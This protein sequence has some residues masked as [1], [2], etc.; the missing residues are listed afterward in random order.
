MRSLAVLATLTALL[1]AGCGG[2]DGEREL[3]PVTTT[4]APPQTG[5]SE[6]QPRE[7]EADERERPDAGRRYSR[8]PASL[9]DCIRAGAGVEDVIVKG[10][11]SEDATFFADLVGGRVDVLGVTVRGEPAE[12]GV[13]LFE[14]EAVARKAAPSAGGGGVAAEAR[15]A[16]VVAAPP[17]ADTGAIE[18]CLG[19]AGYA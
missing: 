19:A 13:F 9:A 2:D 3:P 4:Q 15:G 12:L 5:A 17:D 1:A 18:R 11:D 7:P 6:P 14:S 16:A 10:R 8:T